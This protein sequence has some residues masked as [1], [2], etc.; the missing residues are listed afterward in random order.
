[1]VLSVVIPSYN[2][3]AWLRRAVE[4]A[5][6][7]IPGAVEVIVVDDG[8]T[9]ETPELCRLLKAEF[10]SLVVLRQPNGGLS[11][12]RNLGAQRA[13]GSHLL[14]LDADDELIPQPSDLFLPR[15]AD[16]LQICMEE[17]STGHQVKW[18]HLEPLEPQTGAQYLNQCFAVGHFFTPSVAYVYRLDWYRAHQLSFR[19][20]LLHEDMLFTVQALLVC[21][22]LQRWPVP[23]YRY[24]RRQGSI[25]S[26][27]GAEHQ[28]R[29]VASLGAIAK[30][31]TALAPFHRTVDL[32]W[33]TLFVMDY[34]ARIA[35]RGGGWRAHGLAVLMELRFLALNRVWAPFRTRRAI[36]H[37]TR[38]RMQNLLSGRG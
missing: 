4:S 5:H 8:S 11:S 12:A 15:D 6:R 28:R 30:E 19:D 34:A 20:G 1:M 25:T 36:R 2:C 33:W 10:E 38:Q 21:R 17:I 29:R 14:F 23:L 31:L 35:G 9:D 22:R 18:H 32:G 37:R 27:E 7:F 24:F 26:T 3:A 13:T 16:M